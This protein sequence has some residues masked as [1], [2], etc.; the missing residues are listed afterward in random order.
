MTGSRPS[1]HEWGLILAGAVATRADCRRRQV[2]AVILDTQH[3]VVATGY[4]GAPPAWK[5]CLE[6]GCPR[7][8]LSRAEVPPYSDYG[9]CVSN[10]A[11]ANCLLHA[12][13]SRVE[14]GTI[15]VTARPCFGCAKLIANSGLNGVVWPGEH[16]SPASLLHTYL[17]E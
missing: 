9:N 1:W 6:G 8:L 16:T 4:N 2:G 14:G 5:G 17:T 13:R 10:H 15:Y 7:G 12:D 11:E 3:R